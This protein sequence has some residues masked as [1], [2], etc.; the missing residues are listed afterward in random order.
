MKGTSDAVVRDSRFTRNGKA[1]N[2]SS[3]IYLWRFDNVDL[4][5]IVFEENEG[6]GDG[7]DGGLVDLV[8]LTDLR[9]VNS[10]FVNNPSRVFRSDKNRD[11]TFK[12]SGCAFADNIHRIDPSGDDEA[13]GGAAILIK[14]SSMSDVHISDCTFVGNEVRM[15]SDEYE[16][17][18]YGG[19]LHVSGSVLIENCV[20]ERNRAY[21]G[22]GL[23]TTSAY[24][25]IAKTEF[26]ANEAQHG[27]SI[28]GA[29]TSDSPM[30][31]TIELSSV[32]GV[33]NTALKENKH[34]SGGGFMNVYGGTVTARELDLYRNTADKGKEASGL[35]FESSTVNLWSITTDTN[36][37][38]SNGADVSVYCSSVG[39]ADAEDNDDLQG[40]TI[41]NNSAECSLCHPG[42]EWHGAPSYDCKACESP[43][44]KGL[45]N[46]TCALC[47]AGLVKNDDDTACGEPREHHFTFQLVS[48][49]N[50]ESSSQA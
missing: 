43:L 42:F 39:F 25:K 26:R 28:A 18:C 5:T 21:E 15:G 44:Y 30:S 37:I 16:E 31:G 23:Y 47:P 6:K 50:D 3:T 46:A 22:G 40:N 35:I 8:R 38:L 29:A 34:K 2:S 49:F 19:A 11:G 12:F 45:G 48:T 33:G 4:E 14:E 32:Y 27:G 13:Q 36:V 7:G 1:G 9:V 41:R 24:L 10:T 17:G 20:F